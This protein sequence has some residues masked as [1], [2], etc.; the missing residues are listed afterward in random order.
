M[1]LYKSKD[2]RKRRENSI[3]ITMKTPII[4]DTTDHK[5]ILLFR[6]LELIRSREG[7]QIIAKNGIKPA[8]KAYSHLAILIL[9]LFFCN[10]ISYT[11]QEIEA[12]PRL[13]EFL[14][15]QSVPKASTVYRFLSSIDSDKILKMTFDLFRLATSS[16][17][18]TP[19]RNKRR[20][21]TIIIDSTSLSVDLNWNKKSYSKKQL[22]NE[23]YRWG[24]SKSKK[25]H[26][27]V[28]LTFAIDQKT[29]MPL[30]FNIHPGS[31]SDAVLFSE[32][33]EELKNRRI[34]RKFDKIILDR[35]YYSYANYALAIQKY[36]VIPLIT[37]KKGFSMKKLESLLTYSLFWFGTKKGKEKIKQQKDII[38]MFKKLM[39]EPNKI[40]EE[41]SV[42]E[43]VFK[44]G[45]GNFSFDKIH[46]YTARSLEKIVTLN[47]LLLGLCIS[48]D[49][50]EKKDLQR[51]ANS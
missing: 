10:D 48:W 17:H 20:R 34:L 32:I 11:I 42:I 38:A 4:V 36:H 50:S 29:L 46:R 1:E 25:Y 9:S 28:K 35:G 19:S 40:A 8:H 27:G 18:T 23:P 30:A 6:I 16:P 12:R 37:P 33:M 47:A 3:L 41:R 51:L 26:I 49:I 14:K 45:K 39:E 31:P 15:L 2:L 24:Y 22:E 44:Y 43:D 21:K 5:W 7:K 13:Q